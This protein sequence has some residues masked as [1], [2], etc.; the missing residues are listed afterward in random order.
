M[1]QTA[2]GCGLV[3]GIVLSQEAASVHPGWGSNVVPPRAKIDRT[4][5]GATEYEH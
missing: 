4:A 2:I 1:Q 5:A 3:Q